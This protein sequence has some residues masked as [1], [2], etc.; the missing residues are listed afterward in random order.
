MGERRQSQVAHFSTFN[1]ARGTSQ[2]PAA[3]MNTA[4]TSRAICRRSGGNLRVWRASQRSLPQTG[5][6]AFARSLRQPTPTDVKQSSLYNHTSEGSGAGSV[7][8]ITQ[9]PVK[10]QGYAAATGGRPTKNHAVKQIW[11]E[12]NLGEQSE[13]YVSGCTRLVANSFSFRS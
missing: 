1:V 4:T 12:T 2:E 8:E 6:G 13:I 10:T 3:A 11:H 7:P 9:S 5:A